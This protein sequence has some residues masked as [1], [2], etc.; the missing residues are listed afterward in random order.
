MVV[1]AFTLTGVIITLGFVGNYL[2]KR[3]GIPD[4]LI[5]ILFGFLLGPVF[6]AV[7]PSSLGIIVPYLSALSLLIILFDGGMSL[8]LYKV[9]EESPKALLL[10]VLGVAASVLVTTAFTH[11]LFNWHV[12]YGLLLGTIIGGTS[13]SIILSL[14][15]RMDI[16]ERVVTL[17]SLESVFTD[18]IVVVVGIAI[19]EVITTPQT[20]GQAFSAAQGIAGAFSIGAMVGLLVGVVWLR[21]LQVLKGETNDDIMTLAIS[22]FFYAIV[23]SLG[24]NGAIFSLMFGLVLGNGVEISSILRMRE[25][26]EVSEMM[27]KFMS[28]M[29]FFVRT[30]FFVYLGLIIFIEN[31]IL[32]FFGAALAGLLLLGRYA[33]VYLV[34]KDDQVLRENRRLVSLMLPRGLAAA[35]MAQLVISTN[36]EYASMFPDIII[37]VI[38]STV[39][40]SSVGS[41]LISRSIRAREA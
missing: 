10:G 31:L 25:P 26:F 15:N 33:V 35:I 40:I 1:V 3:T 37:I 6:K 12:I 38:I 2:F 17:L 9:L 41:F 24:G 11:L 14:V 4:N 19:L 20:A 7:D 5:L 30:Y 36:I 32:V 28:Q 29:S 18:A 21:V 27:R 13:S 34:S 22:L 23:E 16:P 8:K 39:I